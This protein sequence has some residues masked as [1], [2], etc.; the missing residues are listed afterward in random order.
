MFRFISRLFK[1]KEELKNE[2]IIENLFKKENKKEKAKCVC[3][4]NMT[5]YCHIHKTDWL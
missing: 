2:K 3:E 5:G 4:M 1:S